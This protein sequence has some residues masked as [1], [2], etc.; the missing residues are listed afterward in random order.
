MIS[1]DLEDE[2]E[3]E[4]FDAIDGGNG[5]EAYRSRFGNGNRIEIRI[6]QE[7]LPMV[8]D[9]EFEDWN[10]RGELKVETLSHAQNPLKNKIREMLS[11]FFRR[12]SRHLFLFVFSF[13]F[14]RILFVGE[15]TGMGGTRF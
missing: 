1:S 12:F 11:V 5:G 6:M 14:F 4:G 8:K 15:V 2:G 10:W 13:I 7:G 9:F 3:G